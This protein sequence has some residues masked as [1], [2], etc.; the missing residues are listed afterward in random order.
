[1]Q[2]VWRPLITNVEVPAK[3]EGL[4]TQILDYV[5]PSRKLR[6]K[7]S[8]TWAWQDPSAA[9]PT[10]GASASSG[11][12]RSGVVSADEKREC[13]PDG[14]PWMPPSV[15]ALSQD[16]LIGALIGKIGGSSAVIKNTSA[17]V[18]GSYCVVEVTDTTKG[19]LYLT[20][21]DV[22]GGMANNSGTLSVSIWEAL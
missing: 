5:G 2:P 19:P 17:F 20:I 7:A 12:A 9:A 22:P 10:P 14:D 6:F 13:G 4:W 21:N 15:D 3:P 11:N 8:G 18:V 16:A 1:M